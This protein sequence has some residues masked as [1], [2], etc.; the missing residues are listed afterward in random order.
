MATALI[1][2]LHLQRHFD[3]LRP[4]YDALGVVPV[5]PPVPGQQLD[6]A[7]MAA[8]IKDADAVIAGDDTI[9]AEVLRAGAASRLRAVIKWGIGTD[10][11]NKAAA[12][13][14]GL[15]VFNTP[16]VFANEV[17]D[18]A[19]SHLLLLT[20]QTHKMHAS[21]L[22]GGWLKVEGRSLNGLTA[23]ILGLGS[24]GLAIAKRA[25]A[26]GMNVLGYDVR[27]LG[28]DECASHGVSQ[29]DLEAL[30]GA[31]DVVF[32][33]CNLTPENRHLL[34]RS[35][36]AKMRDGAFVINVA[37][38]PLIDQAALVEALASGKVA[39]AGLDVFEDEPLPIGD[40]LRAFADRCVF[41][42]HNASNTAEAVSRI[43]QMTTDILF[44]V[45]GLKK[46][47][48]FVPNRV[49]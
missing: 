4:Q 9:D 11:I 37:R 5:L 25:A 45:L 17:A 19:M 20:R 38:G 49:A 7:A 26:F 41:T 46:V 27:D 24:I 23:G 2:C 13:D 47:N 40:P 36:F 39:G 31:S 15:P 28:H 42:T 35:A 18:L 21:V 43:N 12:A 6:A 10:G 16:G 14:I 34:S 3:R 33:A 29:V 44:D 30:F 48:G 22:D 32:V 8:W 1:T